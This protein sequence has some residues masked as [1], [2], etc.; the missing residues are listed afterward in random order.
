MQEKFISGKRNAV[1][2]IQDADRLRVFNQGSFM[3]KLLDI[4]EKRRRNR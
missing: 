1:N 4:I 3:R 2:K